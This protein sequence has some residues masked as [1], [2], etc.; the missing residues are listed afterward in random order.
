M[1]RLD[2]CRL[3]QRCY[4][5]GIVLP[6]KEL[7]KV[8]TV[9][10]E[11]RVLPRTLNIL[12]MNEEI[13]NID[14]ETE[15][16]ENSEENTIESKENIWD[17]G[18]VLGIALIII[19][20]LAKSKLNLDVWGFSFTYENYFDW[21]FI[22]FLGISIFFFFMGIRLNTDVDEKR[23]VN[24]LPNGKQN[25]DRH[26]FYQTYLDKFNILSKTSFVISTTFA[27]FGIIKLLF[28]ALTNLEG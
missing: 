27:V 11:V 17:R 16:Q 23:K 8:V 19:S 28:L 9:G 3:R 15:N 7:E 21:L 4:G 6:S 5:E 26:L 12:K 10:L 25:V 24:D 2:T 20:L 22:L 14:Y 1:Q 18:M 13:K